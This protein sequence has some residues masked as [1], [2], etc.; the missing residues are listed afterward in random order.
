LRSRLVIITEII[1]PYRI[2]IFNT[3]AARPDVDLH[4]LFLSENDPS[5]RQWQVYREEIKFRYEVLKSWRR[6]VGKYNLLINRRVSNTLNRIAPDVVVCGGYNYLASWQAARWANQHS[7]PLLLWTESTAWDQRNLHRPVEWLKKQFLKKCSGFIV[8]GRASREYLNALGISSDRIFTAPNAVD[9]ERFAKYAQT[10]RQNRDEVRHR[11]ALP[12]RYFLFVGRLVKAKGIFD[13]ADAYSQLSDELQSRVGLVFV[14]DGKDRPELMSRVSC[15]KPGSV[16]FPG[17]LQRDEL[18][19]LYALAE[20]LVFPTHSDPWGLVVNEAMSCG[21]PI[22]VT[23]V[24]GCAA[25]LVEEGSN[26][27]VIPARD[28]AKLAAAM[29]FVA[30]DATSRMRMSMESSLRIQSFSP[31]QWADGM[32]RATHA[33]CGSHL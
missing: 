3:L 14:G 32:L 15:I 9:T 8:P 28:S 26:G 18:A 19:E 2:P 5:L 23:D 30:T 27:F 21:L 16:Y 13:L 20:A 29:T 10:A 17:F 22:L 4:V 6:R 11:H 31:A 7:V 12:A 33:M 24:A 1:A 25:D